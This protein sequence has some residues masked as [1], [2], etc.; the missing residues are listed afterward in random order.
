MALT[1]ISDIQE[2]MQARGLRPRKKWGQNFLKERGLLR[3]VVRTAGI[4]AGDLVLEIGSGPGCLTEALCEAGAG[5]VAVEIDAEMIA[6]AR[7]L[8]GNERDVRWL[9]ADILKTKNRLNSEVLGILFMEMNKR[10]ASA[11]RLVGNLP[12]NVSV[13]VIV[14]FLEERIPCLG[15]TVMVQ[16][17]VGDRLRGQPGSPDY[18]YVSVLTALLAD[19]EFVRNVRAEAFWPQPK[20]GS[21]V[22]RITP[23]EKGFFGGSSDKGVDYDDFKAVARGIFAHRRKRWLKSLLLHLRTPGTAG[24]VKGFHDK[25]FDTELR[26]EALTPE[27]IL[28]LTRAA[29]EI[30][31]LP[32]LIER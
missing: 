4:E 1:N 3:L 26:A 30:G 5:V 27:D 9:H 10:G 8:L 12:Y 22:I 15:M 13:P 20:V 21:S 23:F 17:E 7:Q 29:R 31:L 25:G 11:F 32:D 28:E 6:V 24:I 16:K 14:G 18:G 19:V 2:A